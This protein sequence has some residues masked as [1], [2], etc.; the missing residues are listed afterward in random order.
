MFN[1]SWYKSL[2]KPLFS[3]PDWLFAPVW[4]FLYFTIFISIFLYIRTNNQSKSIGYIY[5][6]IQLFLNLV[7]TPVFFGLKNIL[8]GAILIGLID[9]FT[10]LTIYKFYFVSKPAAFVLIPYFIWLLYAT[11]LNLGYLILN[12]L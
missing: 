7:W 2:I 9:I 3:P 12:I 8:A 1:L 11:Y 6:I 4:S 10:A 5:F